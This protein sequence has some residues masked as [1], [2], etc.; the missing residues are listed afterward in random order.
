MN[1]SHLAATAALTFALG[2]S[3]LAAG[4]GSQAYPAA[5]AQPVPVVSGET[6]LLPASGDVTVQTANS[7][8]RGAMEGM[9]AYTQAQLTAHYFAARDARAHL[10]SQGLRGLPRG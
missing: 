6:L 8:L 3:A 9:V 10:A 1:H 2:G 5:A 4:G 7:L